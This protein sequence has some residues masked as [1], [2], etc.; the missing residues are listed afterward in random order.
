MASKKAGMRSVGEVL[1]WWLSR[2]EGDRT[3]SEKYRASM[4]SLMR[5]HVL[6]RLGRVAVRR[7]DRVT[8]YD[9]GHHRVYDVILGRSEASLEGALKRL[10]GREQVRVVVMDMSETYRGIAKKW[11]PNAKLVVDRFHVVKLVNLTL[12]VFIVC[13]PDQIYFCLFVCFFFVLFFKYVF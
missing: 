2:I 10:E 11:F 6:P 5:R 8:L 9:L 1:E 3:R 12:T 4:G 13:L 7:L